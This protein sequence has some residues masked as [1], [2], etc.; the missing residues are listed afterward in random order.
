[1]KSRD[2]ICIL[3]CAAAIVCFVACV[4]RRGEGGKALLPLGFA[5]IAVGIYVRMT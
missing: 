2:I 5:F 3:L 4:L 1:M